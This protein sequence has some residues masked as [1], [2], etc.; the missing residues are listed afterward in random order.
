MFGLY[1]IELCYLELK[2]EMAGDSVG[3]KECR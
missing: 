1:D 3:Y 2:L